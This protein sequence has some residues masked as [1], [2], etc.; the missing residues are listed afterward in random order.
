VAR[1]LP[2]S[3][4]LAE[5]VHD[6][7]TVALEGFTHLIPH[8]AGHELIRQGRR[9]LTLIRMTPDLIYDQLIGMGAARKLV[10]SWGGNPGVGSLHRF[11][12][13]VEN[14]WPRALELEE[15][16][17]AGMAAAWA[18]GA[19]N[20]PFGAL[21]GYRGG[22]L[23]AHTRVASV[24]CPFTGEELAAVPALRPDVGIVHVQ[25]ADRAGNVQLWGITGV[26][27][28]T[29]LASL[30]SLVT[31]EEIVDELRPRPGAVVLPSWVVDTVA[32]APFGAHPSYAHGYYE[33]DN[34]FY[35][36]W[37]EI[38]RDRDRFRAW[39]DRHVLGTAD[40][41][42]YRASLAAEAAPA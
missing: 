24:T 33:R 26:Q 23:P 20:L 8:A 11:R 6:G 28:E 27:K 29:V 25:Q 15:H 10:F 30:R 34:D 9:D 35:V 41:G 2:L 17:H 5:L 21:R 7:A 39:I 40:V 13:A 37:D 16:S 31:V 4:A 14:G 18:A 32:L 42:E 36:A 19:A 38:S 22:D 1:V 3:D 12:D